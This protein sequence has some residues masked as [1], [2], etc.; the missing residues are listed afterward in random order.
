MK[1]W[2]D[3]T[4]PPEEPV[5]YRGNR[6]NIKLGRN[7]I[8]FDMLEDESMKMFGKLVYSLRTAGVCFEVQQ[9]YNLIWISV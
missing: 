1:I 8:E 9:D 3:L 7:V 6:Q 4:L 2:P 5:P